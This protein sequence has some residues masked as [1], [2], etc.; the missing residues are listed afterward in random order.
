[1]VYLDCQGFGINREIDYMEVYKDLCGYTCHTEYEDI[2]VSCGC[3]HKGTMG[4]S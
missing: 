4:V 1:M 3:L 2:W